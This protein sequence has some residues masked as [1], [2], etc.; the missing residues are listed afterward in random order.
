MERE[1]GAREFVVEAWDGKNVARCDG[2]GVLYD[3]ELRGGGAEADASK[4]N[5]PECGSRVVATDDECPHCG[6][7]LA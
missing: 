3:H 6:G 2:C 5:C 4:V 7:A 1:S